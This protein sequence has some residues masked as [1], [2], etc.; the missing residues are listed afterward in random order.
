MQ[1]IGDWKELFQGVKTA[2]AAKSVHSGAGSMGRGER[3]SLQ[4]PT[5]EVFPERAAGSVACACGTDALAASIVV[6]FW[7]LFL[8]IST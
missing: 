2:I 8:A 6:P 4:C 7:T 5:A 1:R 3:S